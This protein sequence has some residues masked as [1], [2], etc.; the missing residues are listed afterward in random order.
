M[1]DIAVDINTNT[2]TTTIYAGIR[3]Y[4]GGR[5]GLF[6]IP[7]ANQIGSTPSGSNNKNNLSNAIKFIP[8]ENTGPEQILVND[9][10]NLIYVL[11]EYDDFIAIIDG[12]T[13]EIK[14]KIILQNP[15]AMSINPSKG[16]LYVASGDSFWFSVID[17]NTNK[18]VAV[19]T[20]ILL[21][22]LLMFVFPF[23]IRL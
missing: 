19:N 4:Q 13:N 8:F 22:H 21:L 14:E 12:L 2:N 11:L 18:V 3:Y 10:M 17:M 23:L 5:A 9:Q 1:S 20:Q 7:D 15:R 16:L 6:I